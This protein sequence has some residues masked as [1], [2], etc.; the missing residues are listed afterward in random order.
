MGRH[1]RRAD[2]ARYKHLTSGGALITHLLAAENVAGTAPL[3]AHAVQHWRVQISIR[4]PWC[5][6]CSRSFASGELWPTAFLLSTPGV[7]PIVSVSGIC[8]RCWSESSP[9][10]IES[11]CLRVLRKIIPGGRWLDATK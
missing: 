7:S 4:R 6:S 10:E 2:L 3:F 11:A 5:I 1:Q 8:S 9:A